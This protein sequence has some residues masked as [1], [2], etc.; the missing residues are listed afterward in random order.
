MKKILI[1]GANGFIGSFLTEKALESN[2]Y[3]WAGIRASS[4]REYLQDERIAFI[5][6][7]Y[8]DKENL[9]RQITAHVAAFGKW[10]YI[11]HNAGITKCLHVSDFD[12]VNFLYTQN[13]VEALQESNA[14]PDKFIYMSSLSV[15]SDAETA[16]GNSK[17]K[18]EQFLRSKPDFPYL[19]MR[20]T[21]VYGPR[22]KDYYLMLKMIRSGWD[23][24]A[25]FEPQQLTFIYVKD[26]AKATFLALESREKHKTYCIS[27]G[28][29]YSDE[30][31]TRIAK[32]ALGKKRVIRLRVPLFILKTVS[33][34]AETI[35]KLTKKPSTL[36]RDKYKIMKQRDWTCDSSP[37]R[38]DTGFTPD[39][40]L[41][42]GIRES[43]TW[44]RAQAWL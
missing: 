35:A 34:L 6:L 21:G 1:T 33:T 22:D 24:T 44:Y 12:K 15:S 32:S 8:G 39:Y 7:N 13:F 14:V 11:V 18:T 3:V 30:E 40:N 20:P 29:V 41:E 43:V 27:D 31:Y 10:D 23:I 5:E 17:L 36:N 37:I 42:Q 9:K 38:H 25:G 28:H 19:I 16:Y 4:N 26:L 2:G